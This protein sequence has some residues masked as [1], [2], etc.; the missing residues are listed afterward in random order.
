MNVGID[1][2]NNVIMYGGCNAVTCFTDAWYSPSGNLAALW[3]QLTPSLSTL[4]HPVSQMLLLSAF[5][6]PL[7][8]V[9]VNINGKRSV[10]LVVTSET[11]IF[12]LYGTSPGFRTISTRL[13]IMDYQPFVSCTMSPSI[14]SS[15]TAVMVVGT[16]ASF[17][18]TSKGYPTPSYI[19][20]DSSSGLS[21]NSASGIISGIPSGSGGIFTVSVTAYNG[22]GANVIQQLTITV[23]SIPQISSLMNASYL[24]G[25]SSPSFVSLNA[26]GFPS[27]VY[28]LLNPLP[29][30]LTL[31]PSSGVISGIPARGTGGIYQIGISASNG[32]AC[33]AIATLVLTINEAAVISGPS[34]STSVEGS[35]GSV[36]FLVDPRRYPVPVNVFLNG[37]ALPN[38]F[39]LTSQTINGIYTIAGMA[40]KGSAGRYTVILG[41][42]NGVLPISTQNHTMI[43]TSS[44]PGVA[45]KAAP[46]YE[47]H[48]VLRLLA[49]ALVSF[50][51]Y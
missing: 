17:A 38:T 9:L 23:N 2:S 46:L 33:D 18:V 50:V 39:T 4:S 22:V 20:I 11:D 3:Y 15:S 13:N 24:V 36:S 5:V 25:S 29:S 10:T 31:N 27:P 26:T 16:S 42:T 14:T 28:S 45:S 40:P 12:N 6:N 51:L 37:S 48:G 44:S 32:I 47:I 49:F 35:S 41:A 30:G 8:P 43:I 21:F 1:S 7:Y 34:T 19:M